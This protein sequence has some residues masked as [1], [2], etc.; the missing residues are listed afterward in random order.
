MVRKKDSRKP[1]GHLATRRSSIID[2]WLTLA[3]FAALPTVGLVN[4]PVY[5]PLLFSLAVLRLAIARGR[6]AIDPGL[7]LVTS[8]FAL[9]CW[10]SCLWS[11]SPSHSAAGALEMTAVMAGALVLCGGTPPPHRLVNW[12]AGAILVGTVSMVADRL[13]GNHLLH[14]ATRHGGATKYNRGIDYLLLLLIPLAGTLARTQRWRLLAGLCVTTAACIA[15]GKNTTA[16]VAVPMALA[17]FEFARRAPRLVARAIATALSI[18]A[19]GLPFALRLLSF[20]RPWLAP[21]IKESMLRRLEIWDYMSDRVLERPLFGWGIWS[22][23]T[24]PITSEELSHYLRE[25]GEGIYPHNQWLEL[26]VETGAV[27]LLLMLVLVLAVLW[28]IRWLD[29][30]MQPFAYAAFSLALMVSLTSFEITTDS[31]W[32]ALA[33]SGFLFSAWGQ[34]RAVPAISRISPAAMP[35]APRRPG[36]TIGPQEGAL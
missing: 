20:I 9:L 22:A 27:G 30:A 17:I 5:A 10:A 18:G 23:K 4:G 3:V 1:A 19:V 2:A 8:A 29:A 13:T 16:W 26:W 33:A 21:H 7:A 14:L 34:A 36:D 15:A 6:I 12:L 31:W 32:A 28:R 11:A 25:H 35:R 24:L